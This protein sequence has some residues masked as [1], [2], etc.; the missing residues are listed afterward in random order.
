MSLRSKCVGVLTATLLL[1]PADVLH[2]QDA[3]LSSLVDSIA[4]DL[5]GSDRVAGISVGVMQGEETLL[6]ETYGYAD[7]EYDIPMPYDAVHE[8]GSIT[9]QFTSVAMLKLWEEGKVDFDADVTAYLPDFDTQGHTISVRRLFDHTSGIRDYLRIDSFAAIVG[10]EHPRDT[11]VSLIEAAPYDFVPGE[12]LIYSNS[13]FF[14]L[15]L[16]IEKVSGKSYADYLDEQFFEPLDMEDSSYCSS[17][18]VRKNRAHGYD[19]GPD[20]LQLKEYIDHTWPYAAGSLC[21]TVR[22]QLAWLR[23]LH[24]ERVL[25]PEAYRMLITPRPLPHGMTPRYAMG[26]GH[27]TIP[28]GRVIDHGGGIPG[29]RS[30][31]RYYPDDDLSIVVLFNT[32][33]PVGPDSVT[34]RIAEHLLGT[35]EPPP[36]EYGGDLSA[37]TGRYE[38]PT[39]GRRMIQTVEINAAGHLT[40][41]EEGNPVSDGN[42][43]EDGVPE[44]IRHIEGSTF[45][46]GTTQYIFVTD[47]GR[48]EELHVDAGSGHFVLQRMGR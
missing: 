16:I 48:A 47:G 34:D 46:L 31:S 19:G 24:T 1:A 17:T 9:K 6:F 4:L 8:I 18:A 42:P 28:T 29:Y 11:L 44:V 7:L 10:E 39:R 27:R 2:A 45:G 13:G 36:S 38:G 41:V 30:F 32:N 3:G 12:A 20:G 22:D 25:S 37:L 35:N 23:A 5:I 15:G 21:S 40:A 43:V 26:V 14:L 33:G